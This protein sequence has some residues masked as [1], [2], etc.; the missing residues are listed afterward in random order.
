MKGYHNQPEMTAEVI[1]EEGWLHT[2]DIA[3]ITKDGVS[4][5][6]TLYTLVEGTYNE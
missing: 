2:G 5:S 4:E 6:I 3:K 1:D